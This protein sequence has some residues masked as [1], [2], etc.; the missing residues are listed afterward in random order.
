MNSPTSTPTQPVLIRHLDDWPRRDRECWEQATAP[1]SVLDDFGRA[2]DW[3]PATRRLA[4]ASYGRW[5]SWLDQMGLLFDQED[6]ATRM[7][8]ERARAFI[9]A[10]QVSFSSTTVS[11]TL[12]SLSSTLRVMCPDPSHPYL[13]K[14]V[15]RLSAMAVPARDR[16]HS[17]VPAS[18]LFALGIRIMDNADSLDANPLHSARTFRDGLIIALLAARPF[19]RANFVAMELGRHL[20]LQNSGHHIRYEGHETK[21]GKPLSCPFPVK[22]E[23]YLDRYRKIH[24]PYLMDQFDRFPRKVGSKPAGDRLWVSSAGTALSETGFFKIITTVTR[25][26][27]GL[28]ITPHMFRHCAATSIALE[29]PESVRITS[30]ILGH[31]GLTTSEKYYNLAHA[32]EAGRRHSDTIQSLRNTD[33]K[34]HYRRRSIAAGWDARG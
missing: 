27:F 28:W 7:T 34:K 19:R 16:R 31:S 12:S 4:I 10:L 14:V 25:K 32:V 23:S 9:A 22:L 24:R 6:P 17:I 21:T 15:V 33:G 30:S 26:E 18:E 2:A 11:M 8:K 29:A 1:H 3:A 13:A 5:L 20:T